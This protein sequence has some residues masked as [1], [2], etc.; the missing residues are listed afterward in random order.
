MNDFLSKPVEQATL[1]EMITKWLRP[2]EETKA[3]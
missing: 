2:V 1:S 3:G